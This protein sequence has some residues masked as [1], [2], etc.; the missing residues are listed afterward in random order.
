VAVRLGGRTRKGVLVVHIASAGIW[1]GMEAV[2]GVLVFT[3]LLTG[4]A[5]VAAT[6]YQAMELFAVWPLLTGGLLCLLSGVVLGLGTKYGLVRYWWV[7]VKLA[8]NVVLCLLV[9]VLLRPGVRDA[10][11]YGRD[12]AAGHGS[13]APAL[14]TST[15]I[16]P[17]LVSGAAL[18]LATA[19]SLYKPWGRLRAG[20]PTAGSR[21]DRGRAG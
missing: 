19:L 5:G 13:T 10:A 16:F 18:I 7:A 11:A 9:L 21:A 1:L 15:M 17:P 3:A 8:L 6:C 4:D 20:S 14:D 12:L 2:L